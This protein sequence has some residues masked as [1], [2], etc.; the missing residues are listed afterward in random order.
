MKQGLDFRLAQFCQ[1][2][3]PT[4]SLNR[5]YHS[6]ELKQGFSGLI[7]QYQQTHQPLRLYF[8]GSVCFSDR[9][10]ITTRPL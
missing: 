4:L 7:P 6:T 3:H 8:Q 1:L 9:L 5:L 10:R 2:I